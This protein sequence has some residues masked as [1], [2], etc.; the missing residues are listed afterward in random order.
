MAQRILPLLLALLFLAGCGSE[1]VGLSGLTPESPAPSA[2]PPERPSPSDPPP[3]S[4]SGTE[5]EVTCGGGP[6]LL[7]ACRVVDSDDEEALLATLPQEG[8]MYAGVFRLT[9]GEVSERFWGAPVRDDDGR[10]RYSPAA[11]ADIAD[12]MLLYVVCGDVDQSEFP[13]AFV[14]MRSAEI[15][16]EQGNG[17]VSVRIESGRWFDLCGLYLR[18]LDDLWVA[19]PQP[20]YPAAVAVD[21]SAA[22]G[23]LT[24][25]E[26]AALVWRFGQLHGVEAVDAGQW[27]RPEPPAFTFTVSAPA[28]N[29]MERGDTLYFSAA[30]EGTAPA[31]LGDCAAHWSEGGSWTGYEPLATFR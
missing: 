10:V 26:R 4:P 17:P 1:G 12:G 6:P 23:G 5:L 25:Q 13:G 9:A 30:R 27:D 22:P 15:V 2:S 7:L 11:F 31:S 19:E 3:D 28:G 20:E 21:L 8:D 16:D 18:V 24:E 14:G 29:R